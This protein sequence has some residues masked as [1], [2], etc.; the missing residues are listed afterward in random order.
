MPGTTREHVNRALHEQGLP[1]DL[2]QIKPENLDEIVD[3]LRDLTVDVDQTPNG[4][5]EAVKV[6][7][8]C[9]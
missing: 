5:G 1:F 2:T 3:Q 9:E 7:I 8:F 4:G 6:R